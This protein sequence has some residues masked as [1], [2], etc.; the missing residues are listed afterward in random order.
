MYKINY[1]AI[2]ILVI[3]ASV[4]VFSKMGKTQAEVVKFF[5]VDSL[6]VA[7]ISLESG[8]DKLVLSKLNDEWKL[9]SPVEA[10]IKTSKIDNLLKK[11]LTVKTSTLPIAESA[12]SHDKYNVSDS[13]STLVT[14]TLNDGNVAKSAYIGKGSNSQLSYAREV[15]SDN[16][17]QLDQNIMWSIKP[18]LKSWR[19]NNILKLAK[20]SII[21]FDIASKDRKM[22]LVN[23]D[24][25]WVNNDNG[26]SYNVKTNNNALANIVN[27]FTNLRVND[28][29][30]NEFASYATRLNNPDLS[31]VVKT[32]DHN[33]TL[34]KLISLDDSTYLMQLNEQQSPLYKVNSTF[35]DSLLPSQEDLT[36]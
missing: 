14:V 30:D 34:I 1:K 2:I 8:E 12:S 20:E 19:E 25:L 4:Y 32:T 26:Q 9:T 29:Y 11:L 24:S 28:F 27:K 10:D 7:S 21:G 22:M 17:Y 3:V 13:L 36:K 6:K 16:V 35:Y 5:D 31:V 23:N 33:D 18:D 15:D